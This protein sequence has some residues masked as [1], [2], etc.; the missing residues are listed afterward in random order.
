MASTSPRWGFVLPDP[1]D[2]VDI[3]QLNNDLLKVDTG[4]GATPC[5]SSTRPATPVAGQVIYETDTHLTYVWDGVLAA[6]Q[7]AGGP[8]SGAGAPTSL[9]GSAGD[10]YFRTDTP[11]AALQ[12]IYICTVTGTPGTWVGIV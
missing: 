1:A 2:T 4:L 6:W 11:A 3:V 9:A 8:R 7:I 10:Y 12:R 5:T